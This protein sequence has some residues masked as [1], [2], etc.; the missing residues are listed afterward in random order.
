MPECIS[1]EI[2][3]QTPGRGYSQKILVGVCSLIPKTLTLIM[4]KIC[5]FFY[6]I[7]DLTKNLIWTLHN[8]WRALVDGLIDSD[9]KTAYP[10]QDQ[11][12]QKR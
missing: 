10:V 8:L 12:G 6:P 7:Y 3:M 2:G 4:T 11:T 5:D 1:V 9:E